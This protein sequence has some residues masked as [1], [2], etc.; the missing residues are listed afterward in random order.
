MDDHAEIPAWQVV[1]G[2]L[3]F[4]AATFGFLWALPLL[5]WALDEVAL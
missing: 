3:L 4:A 5:L 2:G 1:L